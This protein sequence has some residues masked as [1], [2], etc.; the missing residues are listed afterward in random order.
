M[1]S[2][3]GEWGA[4]AQTIR[5]LIRSCVK[6]A[7][8][9]TALPAGAADGGSDSATPDAEQI[10][11]GNSAES[12]EHTPRAAAS[13]SLAGLEP[14]SDASSSSGHETE[15]VSGT[16]GFL[17]EEEVMAPET[18]STGSA[19]SFS[20]AREMQPAAAGGAKAGSAASRQ[21]LQ[22]LRPLAQR[23]LLEA[24]IAVRA[25]QEPESV[26]LG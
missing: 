13:A 11:D 23:S 15:P 14:A 8:G 16:L 24:Q 2:R 6:D 22:A 18:Y 12:N 7:A 26:S 17:P 19:A 21:L 10:K 9:V 4:D 1:F 5:Q 3:L 25:D 20:V